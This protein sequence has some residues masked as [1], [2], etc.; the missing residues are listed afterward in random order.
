M[1]TSPKSHA[2]SLVA[3]LGVL[4][5]AGAGFAIERQARSTSD[6]ALAS[7]AAK[8]FLLFLHEA[9]HGSVPSQDELDKMFAS[10]LERQVERQVDSARLLRRTAQWL[11]TNV[12][13]EGIDNLREALRI[14][15]E[16]RTG[17]V[18]GT[19][20][21]GSFP[22]GRVRLARELQAMGYNPKIIQLTQRFPVAQ[23]HRL[24]AWRHGIRLVDYSGDTEHGRSVNRDS[25]LAAARK[26]VW[27]SPRDALFVE[28]DLEISAPE[29][30]RSVGLLGHEV[31][32][33]RGPLDVAG[34]VAPIVVMGMR[35]DRSPAGGK[36]VVTVSQ[37]LDPSVVREERRPQELADRVSE[38]WCTSDTVL[39]SWGLPRSVGA[40]LAA[41]EGLSLS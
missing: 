39:H 19:T 15:S 10:F 23:L 31:S 26:S 6:P 7:D 21:T 22:T 1:R 36:L 27:T 17:V 11:R 13:I 14:A 40:A 28:A 4:G 37:V 16:R 35:R 33:P 29:S 2:S 32:M 30:G 18:I 41:R 12:E 9:E 38:A 5:A 20:M 8:A 24:I 25:A 3:G 34:D